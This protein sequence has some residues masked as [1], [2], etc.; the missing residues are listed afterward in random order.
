MTTLWGEQ[1]MWSQYNEAH[2]ARKPPFSF[3]FFFLKHTPSQDLQMWPPE[4]SRTTARWTFIR[5][6]NSVGPVKSGAGLV[7]L[8]P[9]RLFFPL[10][11]K[12]VC[13]VKRLI[14]SIT[15]NPVERRLL[16]K[17]FHILKDLW[18]S[19]NNRVQT[20]G[21]LFQFQFHNLHLQS[22]KWSSWQI[23]QMVIFSFKQHHPKSK[24]MLRIY[25]GG[26]E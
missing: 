20:R 16:L 6:I 13:V 26:L 5:Q 23:I 15:D 19:W 12:L 17:K 25:M 21:K 11:K 18:N 3:F 24:L 4:K 10:H 1:S 8:W 14:C 7:R 22:R 9:L 2:T